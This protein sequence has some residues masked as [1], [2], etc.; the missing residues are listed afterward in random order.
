M[1]PSNSHSEK[2][3]SNDAIIDLIVFSTMSHKNVG[4]SLGTSSTRYNGLRDLNVLHDYVFSR[5][6]VFE[7]F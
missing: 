4:N 2:R 7:V 5:E 6:Y 3:E 1:F